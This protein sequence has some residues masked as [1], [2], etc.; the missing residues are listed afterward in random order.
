MKYIKMAEID[1]EEYFK[2]KINKCPECGGDLIE[3]SGKYG[4][5]F[6]CSN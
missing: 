4:K 2:E 6:G 3:R 5:F 1:N